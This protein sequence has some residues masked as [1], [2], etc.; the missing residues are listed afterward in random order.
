LAKEEGYRDWEEERLFIGRHL[1]L[2]LVLY[3]KGSRVE[4]LEG[5]E[6]GWY[7]GI[8]F[9]WQKKKQGENARRKRMGFMEKHLK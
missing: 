4:K 1:M 2:G 8:G 3:G 7:G 5:R 6:V 9:G